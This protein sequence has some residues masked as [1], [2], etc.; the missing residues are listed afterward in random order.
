MLLFRGKGSLQLM[1]EVMIIQ[2]RPLFMLK[3]K[4]IERA[5]QISSVSVIQL[6]TACGGAAIKIVTMAT[7]K[8]VPG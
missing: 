5:R 2:K 7:T 3:R 8:I 6:G 1:P 4:V